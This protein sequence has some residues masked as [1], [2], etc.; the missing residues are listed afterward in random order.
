MR[1]IILLRVA[2]LK[3][4]LIKTCAA[5]FMSCWL[6]PGQK[7]FVLCLVVSSGSFFSVSGDNKLWPN[8]NPDRPL[9]V[10]PL[11]VP[12][13]PPTTLTKKQNPVIWIPLKNRSSGA[14]AINF[15]TRCI[16]P[17]CRCHKSKSET[18]PICCHRLLLPSSIFV[19]ELVARAE[20]FSFLSQPVCSLKGVI[21][22]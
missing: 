15:R 14:S 16:F 5:S 1:L 12:S 20:S 9:R 11:T 22:L 17:T 10:Y 8:E 3:D 13:K 7:L 4:W 21:D 6:G 18:H 2:P 19:S